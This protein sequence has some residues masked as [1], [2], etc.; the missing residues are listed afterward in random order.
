MDEKPTQR[1]PPSRRR[2]VAWAAL[3]AAVLALFVSA[4]PGSASAATR[5]KVTPLLDCWYTNDGNK[6]DDTFVFGYSS[7]FTTTQSLPAGGSMNYTSPTSLS[8][9]FPSSFEP[10]EHHLVFSLRIPG[11]TLSKSPSWTLDGTTL[12]FSVA[13]QNAP[14][15]DP[16]QLPALANG[17]AF[18]AG[19]LLVAGVVG[20]VVL[21]R[22]RRVQASAGAVDRAA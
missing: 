18:A 4:V 21:R 14:T 1:R 8:S 5:P 7:T 2:S 22:V 12:D 3:A 17:A 10:G 20:L 19:L 9:S 16:S 15:C 13:A 6:G 11:N